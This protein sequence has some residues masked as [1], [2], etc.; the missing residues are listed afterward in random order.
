MH[1]NVAAQ[2]C[3][4]C[5]WRP[6]SAGREGTCCVWRGYAR[7]WIEQKFTSPALWWM[8]VCIWKHL[9][10]F[11]NTVWFFNVRSPFPPPP[12]AKPP[13]CPPPPFVLFYCVLFDLK[14]WQNAEIHLTNCICMTDTVNRGWN[15]D[16]GV[17]GKGDRATAQESH[18][19][20]IWLWMIENYCE[21]LD[22]MRASQMPSHAIIVIDCA[23]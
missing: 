11:P 7:T 6:L 22:N 16:R 15:R 3:V 9:C 19:K 14:S 4:T 10:V 23:G 18:L 1:K 17:R 2:W 20:C 12:L 8:I 13:S 5:A 21:L